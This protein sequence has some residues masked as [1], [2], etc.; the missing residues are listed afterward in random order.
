MHVALN[1]KIENLK[2][3][4]LLL[5]K[6]NLRKFDSISVRD[7]NSYKLVNK[8]SKIKPQ[9]VL[10][11]CF[12][13]TP[14]IINGNNSKFKKEYNDKDFILIYGDYFNEDDISKVKIFSK[15]KELVIISVS[16]LNKWASKNILNINPND[17]IYFIKKAKYIFTSM[18]HGVIILYSENNFG[19]RRSL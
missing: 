10:D 12:L 3:K 17:L 7:L 9:I 8:I 14:K 11:P 16:F 5:I 15:K 2:K 19:S 1:S 4:D 13:I 18:F 6:K